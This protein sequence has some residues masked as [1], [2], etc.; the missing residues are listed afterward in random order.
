MS[1][2]HDDKVRQYVLDSLVEGG[3]NESEAKHFAD[4]MPQQ[5]IDMQRHPVFGEQPPPGPPPCPRHAVSAT[6]RSL[7]PQ[8]G[9]QV[10]QYAGDAAPVQALTN[11]ISQAFAGYNGWAWMMGDSAG[12]ECSTWLLARQIRAILD[13]PGAVAF[14]VPIVC[15]AGSVEMAAAAFLIRCPSSSPPP[16]PTLLEKVRLLW[17]LGPRIALRGSSFSAAVAEL[18]EH[19]ASGDHFKVSF[20]GVLPHMQGRGLASQVLRAMLKAVDAEG[21][22]CYLFTANDRNEALYAKYG[23]ATRSRR[24]MGAVASGPL[25][26]E[27][28][29]IRSMLRP[30]RNADGNEAA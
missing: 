10:A 17:N 26:G 15:D 20:V 27:E 18:H 23:F 4:T 25:A 14:A 5:L 29:V 12:A 9:M 24:P 7:S 16:P 30:A 8:A 1:S 21:L 2:A 3:M 11:C 28:M 22:P 6:G 19:D 13:T